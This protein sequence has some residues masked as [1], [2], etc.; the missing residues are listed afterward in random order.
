MLSLFCVD[1]AFLSPIF[2]IA[3]NHK[4]FHLL[5]EGLETEYGNL[6]L[7]SDVRWLSIGKVLDR[8]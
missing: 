1:R 2:V 8:F 3:Q 5:L 4:Q 7:Y 6:I